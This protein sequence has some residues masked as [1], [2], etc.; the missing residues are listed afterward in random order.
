[1]FIFRNRKK[2]DIRNSILDETIKSFNSLEEAR[3]FLAE[4][5][6]KDAGDVEVSGNTSLYGDII[7]MEKSYSDKNKTKYR[8]RI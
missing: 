7:D 4:A 6:N 1:M 2:F 3:Q 8:E 5:G